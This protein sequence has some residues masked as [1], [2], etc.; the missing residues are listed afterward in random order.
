MVA[1]LAK[2]KR[3]LNLASSKFVPTQQSIRNGTKAS[4]SVLQ[5]DVNCTVSYSSPNTVTY[6]IS[7]PDGLHFQFLLLMFQ[8]HLTLQLQ[9]TVT[10]YNSIFWVV[11]L[12]TCITGSLYMFIRVCITFDT[13]LVLCLH[14]FALSDPG[15]VRLVRTNPPLGLDL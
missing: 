14:I 5:F 12:P 1:N 4:S 3:S 11:K 15:G 10:A 7:S 6:S 13:L 2:Y 9:L 8:L